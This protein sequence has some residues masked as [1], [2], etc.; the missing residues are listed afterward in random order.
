LVS[1]ETII[2]ARLIQNCQKEVL[3][4]HKC[5][6]DYQSSIGFLNRYIGDTAAYLPE[7]PANKLPGRRFS[8]SV[9]GL[10]ALFAAIHPLSK[11]F[12]HSWNLLQHQGAECP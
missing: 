2:L 1:Y 7:I 3:L 12:P 5:H 10:Y 4:L 8:A 9:G 6:I 11:D